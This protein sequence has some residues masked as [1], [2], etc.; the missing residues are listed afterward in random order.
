MKPWKATILCLAAAMLTLAGCSSYEPNVNTR[1]GPRPPEMRTQRQIAED[2]IRAS[3]ELVTVIRGI[4]D[5][6][7]AKNAIAKVHEHSDRTKTLVVE[8]VAA[9]KRATP[10]ENEKFESE[11]KD[12]KAESQKSV[13]TAA[14]ELAKKPG[15]PKEAF[16]QV[17]AALN[18]GQENLHKAAT[19]AEKQPVPPPPGF[20]ADKLPESS[21]WAVW[22]LC[23]I[24]LAVCVGF[25]FRDGLWSNAVGLVNVLFAGLLAMNSYEWLANFMMNY[26]DDIHSYV[27]LLDFLAL[28]ICFVFFAVLF[29]ASTDAVSRVRVRFL[30]VVDQAGG[31]VLSLCIGWVM[32]GF[33]LASLHAAPLA[34]YPLFGSFQPQNKMLFGML[35]PDREW[36]GFTKYQSQGPYSGERIFPDNFIETQLERRQHVENYVLG[37]N[38]HAI[39]VNKQFMK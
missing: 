14:A 36:L 22:L 33:T 17:V 35:A 3:D 11:F 38:E 16:V 34:Q 25:L 7:G 2:I 4:N 8:G 15:L 1:N 6:A 28:W 9:Q 12:K 32:V 21:C 23:L 39:R 5:A 18:E 20:M 19:E 26:T 37:N 10:E 27:A 13:F 29:R 30:K 31:I 24:I